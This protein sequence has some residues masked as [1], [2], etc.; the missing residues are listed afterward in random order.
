LALEERFS[1][2]RVERVGAEHTGW[3]KSGGGERQQS[4]RG[5]LHTTSM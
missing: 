5:E 3:Q 1:E 2:R 4:P